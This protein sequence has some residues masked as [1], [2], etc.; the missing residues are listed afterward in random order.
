M[1]AELNRS[2]VFPCFPLRYRRPSERSEAV[3]QRR[4][5]R[6]LPRAVFLSSSVRG[7]RL[8]FNTNRNI[9]VL[10]PDLVMF[11]EEA[12]LT[13]LGRNGSWRGGELCLFSRVSYGVLTSLPGPCRCQ[14]RLPLPG[15]ADFWGA[16]QLT[17]HVPF[18]GRLAPQGHVFPPTFLFTS[19]PPSQPESSLGPGPRQ[20]G[21][22]PVPS[23]C[24]DCA[25]QPP[26]PCQAPCSAFAEDTPA[27]PLALAF[28]SPPLL[29]GQSWYLSCGPAWCDTS[30]SLGKHTQYTSFSDIDPSMSPPS[31][32]M[33]QVFSPGVSLD[34][35]T[36]FRA[37]LRA[38]FMNEIVYKSDLSVTGPEEFKQSCCGRSGFALLGR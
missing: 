12:V 26:L 9:H 15:L 3:G 38:P 16:E 25:N 2:T 7:G 34:C 30:S 10:L 13:L 11:Q 5:L 28:P 1:S 33:P 14:E 8:L 31:L 17:G 23:A 36:Q 6:V 18:P 32:K 21:P 4:P 29:P 19:Q 20:R 24:Q 27:R 37:H 22:A 35:S